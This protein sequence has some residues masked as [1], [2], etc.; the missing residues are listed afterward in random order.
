[1]FRNKN[2]VLTEIANDLENWFHERP[3]W[4]QNAAFRIIQKGNLVEQDFYE[5]LSIC[6][7]E[8]SGE[9]IN[10]EGL[11]ADAINVQE[12]SKPLRLESI[13]EVTGI[14]ALQPSK[15]LDF[16]KTPLCIVYGR[17]GSGKTG[18]VRLLKHVC[19]SRHPGELLPDVF[20]SGEQPQS[21]KITVI[22]DDQKKTYEWSGKPQPELSGVDIYDTLNGLVYVN[23]ENEVAFEPY[24]LQLFTKLTKACEKLKHLVQNEISFLKSAKPRS[25]R[26]LWSRT[27]S[28]PCAACHRD[29]GS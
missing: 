1:M 29:R 3:Q 10:V 22:H 20:K 15:P 19:G 5:L 27:W 8:A 14:N 2:M 28:V 6:I 25:Q 13:S 17:N 12:I 26:R 23:E 11:H 16:G 9:S 4:L 21:A 18:Y 24:I 7:A